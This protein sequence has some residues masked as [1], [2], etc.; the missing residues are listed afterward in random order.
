MFVMQ[1][2]TLRAVRN[3]L[4]AIFKHIRCLRLNT[5]RKCLKPLHLM[6]MLIRVTG[7]SDKANLNY[8]SPCLLN[9]LPEIIDLLFIKKQMPI[10]IIE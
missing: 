5:Q 10:D 4:L 7:F 8:Q 9:G 1:H 2:C 6:I 3:R